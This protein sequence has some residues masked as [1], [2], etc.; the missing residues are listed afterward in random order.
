MRNLVV[1]DLPDIKF[2]LIIGPPNNTEN[3]YFAIILPIFG[4]ILGNTVP[5]L[6]E[7]FNNVLPYFHDFSK[8]VTILQTQNNISNNKTNNPIFVRQTNIPILCKSS[9]YIPQCW[10]KTLFIFLKKSQY[11]NQNQKLIKL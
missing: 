6:M 2:L 9:Q 5:N 7:K 3:C 10:C 11:H 1:F 4:F 8:F